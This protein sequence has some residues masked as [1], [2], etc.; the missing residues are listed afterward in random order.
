MRQE[1]E[2]KKQKKQARGKFK[3]EK[4]LIGEGKKRAERQELITEEVRAKARAESRG[5]FARDETM[6]EGRSAPVPRRESF[7]LRE[8]EIKNEFSPRGEKRS[9]KEEKACSMEK[10]K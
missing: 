2:A 10:G 5:Q 9:E 7:K 1:V 6:R 3:G 8:G 4:E